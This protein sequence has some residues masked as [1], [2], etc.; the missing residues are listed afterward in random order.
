M[1][2]VEAAPERYLGAFIRDDQRYK[3]DIAAFEKELGASLPFYTTYRA[4]GRPFPAAWAQEMTEN[5]RGMVIFWEPWEYGRKLEKIEE[6]AYLRRWGGTL[7]RCSVPVLVVFGSEPNVSQDGYAI[8]Y[9]SFRDK[10]R[11]V[12]T[13]MRRMAPRVEM[14]FSLSAPALCRAP[15]CAELYYPGDE[16]VDWVAF[17]SYDRGMRGAW[18]NLD[19]C[20]EWASSLWP[21]KRLGVTEVG[22]ERIMPGTGKRLRSFFRWRLDAYPQ[23]GFVNYFSY[24]AHNR[25]RDPKPVN[26]GLRPGSEAMEALKWAIANEKFSFGP[27]PRN[28][29][30]DRE[31][32]D[33]D[34][35]VLRGEALMSLYL[36]V[37]DQLT[38]RAADAEVTQAAALQWLREN[39]IVQGFANGEDRSAEALIGLEL[40]LLVSRAVALIDEEWQA[41]AGLAPVTYCDEGFAMSEG[42]RA[43]VEDLET[44][45]LLK[46]AEDAELRLHDCVRR[47]TLDEL[48]AR[49]RA[50]P[51]TMNQQ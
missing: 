15:R 6:D 35:Y 39:G 38:D 29:A 20:L 1:P 22:C 34:P 18:S 50:Q 46:R 37:P 5:E 23:L 24:D 27:P 41:P 10:F 51:S 16:F 36:A 4:Y 9:A 3:G 49:I 32:Y 7:S 33:G 40:V 17:T 8:P 19:R 25:A 26:Y 30:A 43:A 45:G 21:D 31:S 42:V 47:S 2:R 14:V 28:I 48:I 11:L 12:S 13:V 44:R